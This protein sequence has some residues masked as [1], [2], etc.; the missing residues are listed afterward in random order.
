MAGIEFLDKQG[1]TVTQTGFV[2]GEA[3]RYAPAAAVEWSEKHLSI[4][5]DRKIIIHYNE[6]ILKGV[7]YYV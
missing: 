4:R 2:T 6:H 3:T 1:Y 5:N 7:F